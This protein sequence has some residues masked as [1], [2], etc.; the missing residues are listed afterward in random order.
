MC[1][2]LHSRNEMFMEMT[3]ALGRNGDA[4]K[5]GIGGRLPGA[6]ENSLV[7]STGRETPLRILQQMERSVELTQARRLCRVRFPGL[8]LSIYSIFQLPA[9]AKTAKR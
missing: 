4:F 1:E 5:D 3:S 6:T 2:R 9:R 7:S 8:D